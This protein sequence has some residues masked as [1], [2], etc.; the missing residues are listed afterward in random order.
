[1]CLLF[2]VGMAAPIL[3]MD[4]GFREIT[5]TI[6]QHDVGCKFGCTVMAFVA[7]AAINELGIEAIDDPRRL[8]AIITNG[9]IFY[10]SHPEGIEGRQL[11]LDE[12]LVEFHNTRYPRSAVKDDNELLEILHDKAGGMVPGVYT[13][14]NALLDTMRMRTRCCAT[15]TIT[16]PKSHGQCGAS[17]ALGRD[18]GRWL[19]FDSHSDHLGTSGSYACIFDDEHMPEDIPGAY[20]AAL[21]TTEEQAF[22]HVR[23]TFITANHDARAAA[24]KESQP[25]SVALPETPVPAAAVAESAIAGPS[26]ATAGAAEKLAGSLETM[27]VSKSIAPIYN[28]AWCES[29]IERADRLAR[30]NQCTQAITLLEQVVTHTVDKRTLVRAKQL[31]AIYRRQQPR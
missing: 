20:L 30:I 29:T 25:Q 18:S 24:P 17:F 26:T 28:A 15:I 23:V 16:D 10:R 6:G 21:N 13:L 1:M 19:F 11:E 7:A 14:F 8:K 22:E 12:R 2:F 27:H 9:N 3:A 4:N 31:Q 5:C